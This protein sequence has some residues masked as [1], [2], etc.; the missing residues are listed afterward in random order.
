VPFALR[1]KVDVVGDRAGIDRLQDRERRP[2]V[3]HHR[4]AD[5]LERE[6]DLFAVWVAAMFGQKGLAWATRPTIWWSATVITT[7]SE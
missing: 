6:P 4:L 5:V 1:A 3:E 7:V 2:G